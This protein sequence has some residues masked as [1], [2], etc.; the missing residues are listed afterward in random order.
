MIVGA[1]G[2]KFNMKAGSSDNTS[3]FSYNDD[4]SVFEVQLGDEAYVEFL[5]DH[6]G[7]SIE[8]LLY[9]CFE[10]DSLTARNGMKFHSP[11]LFILRDPASSSIVVLIRGTQ[12][13]NDILVDIYGAGMA[14]EE[15]SAHE[16]RSRRLVN[17][18]GSVR[19]PGGS[20][21]TPRF[22]ARSRRRWRAPPAT[23]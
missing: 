7:L 3:L 10:G 6:S 17:R 5:L 21:R 12:D 8:D 14:W 9:C 23:R 19:S 1:Y 13:L 18:R 11:P 20:P 4:A 2:K 16:V 15:G 22:S